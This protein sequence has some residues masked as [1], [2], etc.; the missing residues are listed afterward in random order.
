MKRLIAMPKEMKS[1][2]QFFCQQQVPDLKSIIS[3]GTRGRTVKWQVIQVDS[4]LAHICRSSNDRLEAT[5]AH[6]VPHL[7]FGPDPALSDFFLFGFL[8]AILRGIGLSDEEDLIL[9]VQA[10]FDEISESIRI[11]V[12]MS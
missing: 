6:R 2:T 9:R 4:A 10:T 8:K 7:A 12:D 5:N 1:H 3:S 11:S